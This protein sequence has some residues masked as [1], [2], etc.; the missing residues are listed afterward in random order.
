[1]NLETEHSLSVHGSEHKVHSMLETE[2]IFQ[3]NIY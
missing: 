3:T 2:E 1:M